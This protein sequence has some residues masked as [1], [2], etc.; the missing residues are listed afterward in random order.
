MLLC[1]QFF[2]SLRLYE[3]IPDTHKGSI[4]FKK[5]L[6]TTLL[7]VCSQLSGHSHEKLEFCDDPFLTNVTQENARNWK[8]TRT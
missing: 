4:L 3:G 2:L 6:A 1:K 7:H 5:G 8:V